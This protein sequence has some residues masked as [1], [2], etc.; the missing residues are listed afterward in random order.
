MSK[1]KEDDINLLVPS[2]RERI[3]TLLDTL[4]KQGLQPV[5]FDTARTQEE[6]ARNAARGTGSSR[7]MHL[8]NVAADI[9]CAEHGWDCAAHRCQFFHISGTESRKLG[10]VWGGD[11]PKRDMPHHQAIPVSW[12]YQMRALGNSPSTW[13]QRD[14]LARKWLSRA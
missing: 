13:K 11:W 10:L 4:R 14:E 7:S 1:Y 5:L 12:Q 6:A 8:Y 3:E 9:I 2:F